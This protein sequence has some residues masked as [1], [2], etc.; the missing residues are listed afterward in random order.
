MAAISVSPLAP[1]PGDRRARRTRPRTLAPDRKST[2]L[3][4]SHTEIYTLSLHDALPILATCDRAAHGRHQRISPCPWSWGPTGT[5]NPATNSRAR[6]EEH[7]SE[8]QSHRDLHS[9]PTRR[10]SDLSDVRPSRPWPP[11]AY[12]PLPLVLGTDGHVEPGHELSR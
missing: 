6:S 8:L 2:R 5:S 11:S 3:N 7:T 10:S 9:F 4:S 12:L 1:G